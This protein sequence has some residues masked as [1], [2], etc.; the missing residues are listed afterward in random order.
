MLLIC[1]RAVVHRSSLPLRCAAFAVQG[2]PE[3]PYNTTPARCLRARFLYVCSST[4]VFPRPVPTYIT[5]SFVSSKDAFTHVFIDESSQAMEPE[6]LVPLSLTGAR[7]QVILCGDPRQLGA[8]VR[9]PS[10]RALGLEISLQVSLVVF[11]DSRFVDLVFS[12]SNL[13]G[14]SIP[15]CGLHSALDNGHTLELWR[16]FRPNFPNFTA[17]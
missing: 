13:L 5:F 14:L 10:A 8:A 17:G 2:N 9:S 11:V 16:G 1:F 3:V 15:S 12:S 7:A 4:T 6:L